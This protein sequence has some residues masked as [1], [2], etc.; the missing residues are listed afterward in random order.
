[1]GAVNMKLWYT[2]MVLFLSLTLYNCESTTFSSTRND[3]APPVIDEEEKIYIVD[4]TGKQ[5]DITHA[6]RFFNFEANKFQS[7]SGPFAI[8]PILDPKML[9]PGDP[10]YPAPDAKIPNQV[11]G[12]TIK[13]ESRAYPLE[14][15]ELHEIANDSFG[16]IHVAVGF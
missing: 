8:K 3:S 7:G 1:M 4:R 14:F 15:L 2:L 5:W 6:V 12:T 9:S 16:N 11:I 10:G 13:G